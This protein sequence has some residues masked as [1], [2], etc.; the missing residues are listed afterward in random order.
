MHVRLLS[1]TTFDTK[2]YRIFQ[3]KVIAKLDS[4]KTFHIG[5]VVK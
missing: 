2:I 3:F 5:T 1:N 4:K